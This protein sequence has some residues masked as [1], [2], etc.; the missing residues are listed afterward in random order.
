MVLWGDQG[1]TPPSLHAIYMLKGFFVL[2][3]R[4]EAFVDTGHRTHWKGRSNGK[5]GAVRD[6]EA[7]GWG[8]E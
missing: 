3:F 4:I 8:L 1:L 7:G 2:Y 6:F 5:S